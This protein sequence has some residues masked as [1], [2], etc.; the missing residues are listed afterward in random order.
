VRVATLLDANDALLVAAESDGRAF[1]LD[2]AVAYALD[3]YA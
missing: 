2:E 1:T 3:E